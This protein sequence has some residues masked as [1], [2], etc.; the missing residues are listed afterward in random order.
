M[1]ALDALE[2]TIFEHLIESG[3]L[4]NLARFLKESQSAHIRS[5]GE[6]L[7]GSL[8][9][10]FAS[11]AGPGTHG[12]YFWTQWL[13][14]QMGYARNSHSSLGYDPF[15]ARITEAGHAVTVID[16]PYVPLAG[17]AEVLQVAAWGT[18]DEVEPASFPERYGAEFRK[19]F[20]KHPLGFDTVEPQTSKDKLAM[21]ESMRAG[22][23]LRARTTEALLRERAGFFLMVFGETHK[24][25]HYLAS[26]EELRPGFSNID[27]LARILQPLDE[28]WPGIVD[29]T[30][31]EAHMILFSLHG[32]VE[33]V[34]YSAS[35]GNQVLALAS[36]KEPSAA[37]SAPDILRRLRNLLPASL[38]RA[39]WR[40]LP[41]RFRA[42]RTGATSS[43]GV[44]LEHDA[45]FRIAHDGHLAVRKNLAD[46]ERDGRFAEAEAEAAIAR[47]A[48]AALQFTTPDGRPAFNRIWRN[49]EAPGPR[50]HRL[51]DAMLLANFAVT[52]VDRIV[53]ADGME[54]TTKVPEARNGIHNG[55][56]F[57]Y[58]RP[59]AGR[60]VAVQSKEIDNRDL[61]PSV[62]G[63]FGI[64]PPE[65]FEGVSMLR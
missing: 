3:A 4:P 19:R 58:L 54:L 31:P 25:G 57:F 22:V 2:S 10:T 21:V 40:R 65:H 12:V 34:D 61:A 62:L 45:I 6:T 17:G 59:A 56:G 20:G 28:A 30:G 37:V 39:V 11:G 60:P 29:A 49:S 36:G 18:H 50:S 41:A 47:F 13:E 23:A 42:A 14:E 46:R 55:L 51:P 44:D 16:A 64:A 8:W 43:A 63:L 48:E 7:H 33:Q 35:L 38:H 15:W 26:P 32:T 27:A 1:I 52:R 53:S 5:D 24:A 9:P